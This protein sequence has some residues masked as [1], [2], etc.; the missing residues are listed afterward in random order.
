MVE[1]VFFWFMEVIFQNAFVLFKLSLERPLSRAETNR[2]TFRYFKRAVI[3]QLETLAVKMEQEAGV[4]H[5]K[6]GRPFKDS[7]AEKH[8]PGKHLIMWMKD[9]RRCQVC[10]KPGDR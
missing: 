8:A 2:L 9:D 10:S 4:V 6:R 3:V 5:P 1:K 7:A